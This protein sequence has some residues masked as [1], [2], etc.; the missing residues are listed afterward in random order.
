M[1]DVSRYKTVSKP[2]IVAIIV[3]K[4]RVLL[5]KRR[6]WPFIDNPG[7]WS[8]LSGGIERG[9]LPLE[10]AYREIQEETH[11]GRGHLRL[12]QKGKVMVFDHRKGI[13]WPNWLF[14]FSSDY[15]GVVKSFENA[16]WRWARPND[17]LNKR[18][19]TNI[20]VDEKAL[21]RILKRH[22]DE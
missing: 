16:D 17:I 5:L 18:D 13:K 8:F 10:T 2:G 20:F 15:D 9:E 6:A 21:L 19:Y 4:K 7:I 11:L 3:C 12:L 14:V 1:D 22:L